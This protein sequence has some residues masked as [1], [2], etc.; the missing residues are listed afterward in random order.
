M[1]E[2]KCIK[3]NKVFKQKCHYDYHMNRKRPCKELY[4]NI[5]NYTETIPNYT[6]VVDKSNKQPNSEKINTSVQ[7][8]QENNIKCAYCNKVFTQKSSLTRHLDK[9]CKAKNK[10]DNEKE[11]LL[12]KLI[13]EMGELKEK[14]EK[15][16]EE[17]KELKRRS[18]KIKSRK[19]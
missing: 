12:Q 14:L 11:E 4:Q 18:T 5:P 8:E 9:R 15:N 13:K 16:N 6:K 17:N 3:C 7:S 10:Q 19:K 2:Y 1:V